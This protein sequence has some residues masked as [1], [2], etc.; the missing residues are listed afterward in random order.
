MRLRYQAVYE[1]KDHFSVTELCTALKVSRSGYYKYLQRKRQPEKDQALKQLIQSIYQRRKG[2]YGYRRVQWELQRKHGIHVNHKRV[3]R[4]M[5]QMGLASVIRRKYRYQAYTKAAA[6]ARTADNLLN[7][8][9]HAI[10]PNQKWVTDV[11]QI[12]VR[13]SKMYL[14]VIMDLFNNEVIAYQTS[15]RNDNPLVLDTVKKA[16]KK[17]KDVYHNILHSDRGCQYK[18]HD[19]RDLLSKRQLRCS[20]SRKGNCWDN[21]CV[22]SFFSH[23]KSEALYPYDIQNLEE[24]QKR[25]AQY[26]RFYNKERMQLK[27]NKLTPVEYRRQLAA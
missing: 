16:L 25:I 3:Y 20:M 10:G 23:L 26:I 12:R 5:N 21:A 4:L 14:S 9:F 2:I 8:D 1:L 11:T 13:G 24:A 27:L 18:S 7:R 22:E 19:Y 6:E 15:T 17:R